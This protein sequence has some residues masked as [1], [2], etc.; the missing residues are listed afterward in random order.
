MTGLAAKS[1]LRR[2]AQLP[3][4]AAGG[5]SGAHSTAFDNAR[6]DEV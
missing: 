6:G 4:F 2:T 5:G 1:R 3:H